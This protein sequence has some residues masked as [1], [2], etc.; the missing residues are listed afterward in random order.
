MCVFWWLAK[1]QLLSDTTTW[2]PHTAWRNL[3]ILMGGPV[4][5][6]SRGAHVEVLAVSKV[7]YQRRATA[8]LVNKPLS[9]AESN[10]AK[11][12]GQ[13]RRQTGRAALE[14]STP[15]ALQLLVVVGRHM[16]NAAGSDSDCI[17]CLI[18]SLFCR[19]TSHSDSPPTF[20]HH[21]AEHKP[22]LKLQPFSW[23]GYHDPWTAATTA[24]LTPILHEA[25]QHGHL[26]PY[27]SQSDCSGV[28]SAPVS[29][30]MRP[31]S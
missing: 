20:C 9:L 30:T 21:Q 18:L 24:S 14:R 16:I 13:T 4:N 22:S 28:K 11:V 27:A 12:A 29:L 1:V 5:A 10:A 23:C 19:L 3:T 31:A 8:N 15:P 17:W 6:A 26:P 2:F 25:H 7:R